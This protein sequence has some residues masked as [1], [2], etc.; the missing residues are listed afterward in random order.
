MTMAAVLFGSVCFLTQ[1]SFEAFAPYTQNPAVASKRRLKGVKAE[2]GWSC[3]SLRVI[4]R[5]TLKEQGGVGPSSHPVGQA[6]EL[7]A[8]PVHRILF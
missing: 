1:L 8:Q 4:C 3:H 6:G 2:S 7:E 5:R